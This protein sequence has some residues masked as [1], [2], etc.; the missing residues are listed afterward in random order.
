MPIAWR[1]VWIGALTTASLF[2]VGQMAIGLYLTHSAIGSAYGAAGAMV[3]LLTWLY[4]SSQIFLFGAEFTH[5]YAMR[6][7][8][9]GADCLARDGQAVMASIANET[10]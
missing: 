2:I 6:C 7:D 1:D 5:A 4:Y 9:E 8:R 10:S 3:V